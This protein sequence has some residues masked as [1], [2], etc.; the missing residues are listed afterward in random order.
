MKKLDLAG[1]RFGRLVAISAAPANKFNHSTWLC[2]CDCGN[3]TVTETQKLRSGHSQSCGCAFRETIGKTQLRHGQCVNGTTPTYQAWST[4]I[5]RCENPKNRKY[6]DY[7]G[8]GI[9]MCTKWRKDFAAFRKDM[10]DRPS[11]RTLDRI[12]N[13]GN[14]EPGN[15]RW[16]TPSEQ[17]MN[18]R[19][20]IRVTVNGKA[21][22]LLQLAIDTGIA[23]HCLYARHS[24]GRPLLRK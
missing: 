6:A 14:Y 2:E 8:R 15:C 3:R 4:A 5:D 21:T 13:D 22:T 18:R 19:N 17:K 24:R 16:A 12:N 23:Y 11:G 10:G 1:K 9:K 20:T 7:G